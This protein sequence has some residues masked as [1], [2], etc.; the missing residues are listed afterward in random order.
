MECIEI[1][2][3]LAW[4]VASISNDESIRKTMNLKSS[5]GS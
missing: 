3:R 4:D 1:S 2:D 5:R